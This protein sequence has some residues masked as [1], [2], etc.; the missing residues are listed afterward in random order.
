MGKWET[1]YRSH[2]VTTNYFIHTRLLYGTVRVCVHA[3][4]PLAKE[5]KKENLPTLPNTYLIQPRPIGFRIKTSWKQTR[6]RS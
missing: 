3:Q 4:A 6:I 2:D 5:G 1:Q